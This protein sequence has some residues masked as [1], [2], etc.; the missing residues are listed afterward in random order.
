[1]PVADVKRNGPD[2]IDIHVGQQMRRRRVQLGMSQESLGKAIGLTFQQVQKYERGAN[3]V[4]A[5]RLWRMAD[6][7][8]VPI[9][10]FFEDL[11]ATEQPMPELPRY[12]ATLLRGAARMP[13]KARRA[14]IAIAAWAD[15][16]LPTANGS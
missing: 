3:R 16:D 8:G 4:S 11:P 5:S 15:E 14:L 12:A 9:A 2:P 13:E 7:L 6:A 10:Y 1:M